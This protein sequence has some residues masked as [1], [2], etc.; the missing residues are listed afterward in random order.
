MSAAEMR[1]LSQA[2]FFRLIATHPARKALIAY[3]GKCAHTWE[4]RAKLRER[5]P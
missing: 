3:L 1:A 2:F 4:F 5:A